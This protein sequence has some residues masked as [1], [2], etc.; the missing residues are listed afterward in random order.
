VPWSSPSLLGLRQRGGNDD[1]S[2]QCSSDCS[3]AAQFSV[4]CHRHYCRHRGEYADP[5][6]SG[7]AQFPP[8]DFSRP[9][10]V[11]LTRALTAGRPAFLRIGGTQADHTYYDLSGAATPTPPPNYEHVLTRGQ[12]DAANRFAQSLGLCV[13]FGI[14]AGSGPRDAGYRWVPDNARALLEYTKAQGYPLRALEFGNEPNVLVGTRGAPA[15]YKAPSYAR[16]IEFFDRLRSEIVPDVMF[17]G[18]GSLLTPGDPEGERPIL[19]G[20]QHLVLGP[21]ARDVLPLIGDVYDAI[22]YHFYPGFSDRCPYTPKVPQD[23]LA[24][25]WLD[26]HLVSYR[27]M[28]ALRDRFSPGKPL[29]LGETGSAACGGQVNYS[30]RFAA[31]FFWLNQLGLL[32]QAGVQL[33]VRQALE[34]GTY[35]LLEQG[36]LRPNPDYW[37]S[38]LWRRLMGERQLVVPKAGIPRGLR[39]FASCAPSD[40]A[41]QGSV[42]YLLLNP[43]STPAAVS[44]AGAHDRNLQVWMVTASSAAAQ[45]VVLNGRT[46]EAPDGAVPDLNGAWQFGRELELPALSYAFVVDSTGTPACR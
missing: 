38:V 4:F 3:R 7:N 32:A 12:W 15:S 30:D 44:F 17:V 24:D 16:D 25:A 42:T 23:V 26:I 21:E 6:S 29:W 9:A 19:L 1:R 41:A 34:G 10:L 18:P 33:V 27:Y 36:T 11:R 31:S 39:V 22:N 2:L 40:V 37:A 8:Y 46:L 13:F 5:N 35:G 20:D 14:N 43:T 28:A 45:A